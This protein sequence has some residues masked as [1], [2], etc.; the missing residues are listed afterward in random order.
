[1]QALIVASTALKAVGALKEGQAQAASYKSAAQANLYN[2]AVAEGNARAALEQANAREEGQRRQFGQLQGQAL[3][4]AAQSGAG[5]G[6][7]NADVLAQ[8][9]A[10][11]ELD[12]LTIRYE[13]QMQ[14]GGM[15]AQAQQERYQAAANRK[16]AGRA[17]KA[18]YIN[19]A[20]SVLSGAS[21]YKSYKG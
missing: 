18:A 11:N 6:G 20:S 9:A 14:S 16:N 13:G 19:A 1:M 10:N 12:A 7:S 8:S 4:A 17:M 21:D 5:M 2:A 3:A 15:M